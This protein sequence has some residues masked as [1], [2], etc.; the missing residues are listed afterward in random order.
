MTSS[1]R[2]FRFVLAFLVALRVS[3]A[4]PGSAVAQDTPAS[5]GQGAAQAPAAST[6]ASPST[7]SG[8][9]T[10]AAPPRTLRAYWHV[11]IAFSLAWLLLFGYVVSVGRRFA[12]V[13][14][15]LEAMGG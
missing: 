1:I 4:V 11:W 9:P 8:L 2:R 6:T 3:A 13:E 14:R 7:S 10:E 12:K 15:D 5:A